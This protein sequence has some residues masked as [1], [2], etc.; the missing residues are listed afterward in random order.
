MHASAIMTTDPKGGQPTAMKL[1]YASPGLEDLWQIHFFA[2]QRPGIY[3][4][5]HVHAPT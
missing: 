4:A 3:G 2:A 1:L 5:A